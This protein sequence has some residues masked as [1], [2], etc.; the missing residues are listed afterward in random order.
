MEK[1]ALVSPTFAEIEN[2]I[3]NPENDANNP[4]K[5]NWT[6][7]EGESR[8]DLF[9][10]KIRYI[11]WQKGYYENAQKANDFCAQ[12]NHELEEA[13]NNGNLEK[14]NLIHI[15]RQMK[16]LTFTEILGYIPKA[17]YNIHHCST[18]S[19]LFIS[20]LGS[21]GDLKKITTQQFLLGN[22]TYI[23]HDTPE[24]QTNVSNYQ[25]HLAVH[26]NKLISVYQHSSFIVN[27]LAV[28]GFIIFVTSTVFNIKKRNYNN[29]NMFIVLCGIVL[30]AFLLSLEVELFLSWFSL[31]EYNSFVEFYSV[32]IYPLIATGKYIS[33]S[34]GVDEA[35]K[36]L[37]KRHKKD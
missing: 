27:V 5:N 28:I 12:V 21:S 19:N 10:W 20:R 29:I 17:L 16:G 23:K 32:S 37:K 30:S 4:N 14:D 8:G 36:M 11:M 6:D 9:I 7:S 26:I 34:L 31:E 15:T 2:E 33:I 25:N 35:I 3:N 22:N 13:F 24:F 1:A 18:Y